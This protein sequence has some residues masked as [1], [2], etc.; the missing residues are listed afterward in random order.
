[1]SDT[2][3]YAVQNTV[4]EVPHLTP[5]ASA[6]RKRKSRNGRPKRRAPRKGPQPPPDE[7]MGDDEEPRGHEVD[8]L[9]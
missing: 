5:L 9:A 4:H 7:P 8:L 1:M 3:D 2:K 6:T